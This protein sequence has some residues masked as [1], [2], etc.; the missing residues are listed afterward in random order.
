MPATS[1]TVEKADNVTGFKPTFQAVDS[2]NGNQF[3]NASGKVRLKFFGATSATGTITVVRQKKCSLGS[4]HNLVTLAN[5]LDNPVVL[6]PPYTGETL[7]MGPF[8]ETF[9]D[10]SGFVQVTYSGTVTNIAVHVVQDAT[11]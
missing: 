4:T 1:W 5:A 10:G 6:T 11:P 7:D 2:V 3:N 9:N 8:D